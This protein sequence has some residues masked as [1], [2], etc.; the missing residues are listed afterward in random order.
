MVG[1]LHWMHFNGTLVLDSGDKR[2]KHFILN[3]VQL[4]NYSEVIMSH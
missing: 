1:P 2:P 3:L 4:L